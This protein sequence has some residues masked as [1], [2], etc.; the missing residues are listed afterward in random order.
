M[1]LDACPRDYPGDDYGLFSRCCDL[2]KETAHIVLEQEPL[3][4]KEK[5][6]MDY[7]SAVLGGCLRAPPKTLPSNQ[8]QVFTLVLSSWKIIYGIDDK[9]KHVTRDL[10]YRQQAVLALH[11]LRAT[12]CTQFR[13]LD[14]MQCIFRVCPP[15]GPMDAQAWLAALKDYE[16]RARTYIQLDQLILSDWTR[17]P[18]LIQA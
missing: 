16:E 2:V 11:V 9:N 3:R 10:T 17:G 6:A 1:V 12:A 14:P 18:L 13:K 8:V 4:A 15:H 7:A 5:K